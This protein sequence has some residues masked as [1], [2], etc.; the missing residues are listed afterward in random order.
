MTLE[1]SFSKEL[2]FLKNFRQDLVYLWHNARDKAFSPGIA[3]GRFHQ[4]IYVH[5]GEFLVQTNI[6][7]N[8]LATVIFIVPFVILVP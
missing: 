2:L 4:K 3:A 1:S 7:I 5:N 8:K 6:S